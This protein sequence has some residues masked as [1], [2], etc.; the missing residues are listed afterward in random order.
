MP[1]ETTKVPAFVG[2]TIVHANERSFLIVLFACSIAFSMF[3][4]VCTMGDSFKRGH[5]DLEDFMSN[6][7]LFE[8]MY[9]I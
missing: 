1:S 8:Y 3:H 7:L 6:F 2:N 9:V 5:Q 4:H